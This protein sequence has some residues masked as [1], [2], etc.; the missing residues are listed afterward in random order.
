MG[1]LDQVDGTS[2]APPLEIQQRCRDGQCLRQLRGLAPR[3][4]VIMSSGYDEQELAGEFRENGP[5]GFIQKPYHLSSLRDA[6]R[7]LPPHR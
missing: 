3:I 6:I 7:S 4:R 1:R 2:T 5:D